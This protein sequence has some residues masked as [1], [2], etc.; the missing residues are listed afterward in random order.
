MTFSDQVLLAIKDPE[1]TTKIADEFQV[2]ESA[3][4]SW[5]DGNRLPHEKLQRLVLKFI[6]KG[7]YR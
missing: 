4:E 5:A 2:A 6:R 3:V 7:R 1:A